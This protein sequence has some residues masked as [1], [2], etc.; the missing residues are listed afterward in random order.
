MSLQNSACT[1]STAASIA[2]VRG[3]SEIMSKDD[4]RKRA[5]VTKTVIETLSGHGCL[6][7]LSETNQLSIFDFA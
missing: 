7:G 5:K 4:L 3:D 6:E 2:A 1:D